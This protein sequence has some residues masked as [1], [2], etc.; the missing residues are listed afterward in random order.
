[1]D[2]KSGSS[3][4]SYNKSLEKVLDSMTPWTKKQ[5]GKLAGLRNQLKSGEVMVILGEG[6]SASNLP[7]D[8]SMKV[9]KE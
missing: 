8:K 9:V 2:K 7:I 6:E 4:N 1:M 3:L 5:H